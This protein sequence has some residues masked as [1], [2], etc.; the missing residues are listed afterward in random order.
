M[1]SILEQA[2]IHHLNGDADKAAELFHEFVVARARQI[3]ESMRN[4]EDPVESFDEETV[5]ETYFGEEDLA[6]LEDDNGEDLGAAG[7]EVEADLGMDAEGG[8]EEGGDLGD[9]DMDGE[10]MA[11]AEGEGDFEERLEDLQAE[12]ERLIADFE[13]QSGDEGEDGDLADNLD[14]DM[15]G[16]DFGAADEADLGDEEDFGDD[17]EFEGLGESVTS[18]LEKVQVSLT[19][20]G[21]EIAAGGAI[22]QQKKSTLPQKGIAARQGGTPFTLKSS[23]HK[24]F[25]RETAPSVAD[26][27]KRRNTLAKG[28]DA[29]GTVPSAKPA[30]GKEVGAGGKTSSVNTKS[31]TSGVGRK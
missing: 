15:G 12:L 29:L 8:E 17:E 28:K 1:R 14:D 13:E 22:T 5:A 30:E 26:M 11:D 18:E 20:D 27:K 6:E 25:E 24:G 7:D 21:K 2:V 10:E 3:H 31:P 9:F 4:G 23:T 16:D 19:Q